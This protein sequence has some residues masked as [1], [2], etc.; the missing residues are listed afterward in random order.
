[1]TAV[2]DETLRVI[3][4][5]AFPTLSNSGRVKL[6]VQLATAILSV[7]PT[8]AQIRALE[9]LA[10][11]WDENKMVPSSS[12]PASPP[13]ITAGSKWVSVWSSTITT[14]AIGDAVI[15]RLANNLIAAGYSVTSTFDAETK[16]FRFE[17]RPTDKPTADA[18]GFSCEQ[19]EKDLQDAIK[20]DEEAKDAN[21]ELKEGTLF[22]LQ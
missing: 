17:M 1:M 20:D 11:F 12:F 2:N 5:D 8:E 18:K 22:L 14:A 19:A 3:V 16:R 15:G 9:A 13:L 4:N 7:P 10:K 21:F 6:Y